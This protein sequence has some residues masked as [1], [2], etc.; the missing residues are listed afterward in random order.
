MTT[1]TSPYLASFLVASGIALGLE[2]SAS[3]QPAQPPGPTAMR[4]GGVAGLPFHA[5]PPR[6]L[7]AL[8]LSEAQQDQVFK[9]FHDQAPAVR[10]RMKAARHAR[11]ELKSSAAGER[12]D[13]ARA[14]AAAEAEARAIAEVEFM[15]A[16]SMS[17]VREI[18]TPEQRTKL[19][20]LRRR[21]P[22]R[23]RR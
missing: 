13:V 3:A 7:R 10:E 9:I 16:Q 17:K 12:F 5:G 2:T 1:R 14:H 22:H 8:D 11:E 23:T 20:E 18:L 15:R 21:D 6:W 19:D 4:E